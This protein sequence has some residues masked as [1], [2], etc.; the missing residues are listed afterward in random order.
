M[1]AILTVM[2]TALL[3]LVTSGGSAE[4]TAEAVK[5]FG[6]I[7][8]WSTDCA[9]E[10]QSVGERV[11]FDSSWLGVVTATR[12]PPSGRNVSEVQSAIR[13]TETKIKITVLSGQ[14]SDESVIGKVGTKLK[15]IERRTDGIIVARDG[16]FYQMVDGKPIKLDTQTPTFE[17]CLN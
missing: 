15:L 4:S 6:L 12:V 2:L 16:F 17:R 5:T 14:K 9:E 10:L 7:G 11:V 8:T 1:Y 13:V 3:A